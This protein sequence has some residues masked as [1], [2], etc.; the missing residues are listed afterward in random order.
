MGLTHTIR[1]AALALLGV[2]AA[3][4]PGRAA[5]QVVQGVS[6]DEILIGTIQ[7]LSGPVVA[8]SNAAINGLRMR[9]DEANA[10]GGVAGRKIRLLI[11]DS[12]YDTRRA[13]LA[14]QKLVQRDRIFLT[15]S[16]MGTAVTAATL[17][18][19]LQA[20]VVHAFPNAATQAAFD[21]P[22]PLKFATVLPWHLHGRAMVRYAVETLG[23]GTLCA[24]IQD[25]EFGQDLQRGLDAEVAARRIALAVRTSYKR[26]A[27]DFSSQ[28]ARL[29]GANCTVVLLGTT[30]RETVGVLAEARK[31]A[32][33][34]QFFAAPAAFSML[35][36]KLGADVVEGLIAVGLSLPPD[37]DSPNAGMRA[38]VAAYQQKFGEEP[39]QYAVGAYA[40][41]ERVLK[42]L[43]V[44]GKNLSA[45]TFNAAMERTQ[46]PAIDALGLSEASFSPTRRLAASSVR[47]YQ[48]K[49][50]KWLPVSDF[51]EP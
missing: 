42:G 26:G 29:K 44:A 3:A 24:L 34:A 2:W 8:F 22:S 33:D 27:T 49:Q 32:L 5:A 1:A 35:V 50:G 14:A 46:F 47:V 10:A 12:G 11:E 45:Q 48:I 36:P 21:P 30:L 16:N 17:P 31:T 6:S 28:V 4:Q 19:F 15:M 41:A 18:I 51:I 43:E 39:D 25:D 13:V 23:A 9:F 20:G 7:D 38:W 37:A 40:A